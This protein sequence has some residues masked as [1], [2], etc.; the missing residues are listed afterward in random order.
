M[1]TGTVPSVGQVFSPLD[2]EWQVDSRGYSSQFACQVVW[3]SGQVTFAVA[4]Q[5][6]E[7]LAQV[8][9]GSTTIWEQ[10]QVYGERLLQL[11]TRQQQHSNE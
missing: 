9:M 7:Q 1:N 4:S 10:T 8:S 2:K 5:I 11:E 3:L 6:L